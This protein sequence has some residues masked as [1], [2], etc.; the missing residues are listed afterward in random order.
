VKDPSAFVLLGNKLH[1]FSYQ[2]DE[3]TPFILKIWH[4]FSSPS[5]MAAASACEHTLAGHTRQG[6]KWLT[7]D[8]ELRNVQVVAPRR[9]SGAAHRLHRHPTHSASSS[10]GSPCLLQATAPLL[11]LLPSPLRRGPPRG[12]A[13]PSGRGCSHRR[14]RH[15]ATARLPPP[16]AALQG[17]A[18][19]RVSP[20][21]VT[22]G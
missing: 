2:T 19:L 12:C 15:A 14:T 16:H 6:H 22:S 3:L 13:P 1:C 9:N 21:A 20:T 5:S 7:R 17:R 18:V 8:C 11:Y 4:W 10:R